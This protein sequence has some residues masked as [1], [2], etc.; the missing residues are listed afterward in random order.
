MEEQKAT[1][2]TQSLKSKKCTFLIQFLNTIPRTGSPTI[3]GGHR[4]RGQK[5]WVLSFYTDS[6]FFFSSTKADVAVSIFEKFPRTDT[7]FPYKRLC[8]WS[9]WTAQSG[10]GGRG[11]KLKVNRRK[12]EH[13]DSKHEKIETSTLLRWGRKTREGRGKWLVTQLPPQ[14]AKGNL[15]GCLMIWREE[16]RGGGVRDQARGRSEWLNKGAV[17]P[18]HLHRQGLLVFF[19][20]LLAVF[21]SSGTKDFTK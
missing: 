16:N 8:C 5:D 13:I 18:C 19:F 12:R 10:G 14:N 6:D 1:K 11:V 2:D 15:S 20:S 7:W 9:V 17:P 3:T 4:K 21:F